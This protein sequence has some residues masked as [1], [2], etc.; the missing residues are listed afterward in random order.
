MKFLV[1]KA[2][3]PAEEFTLSAAYMLGAD[4][5]PLHTTQKIIINNGI[6]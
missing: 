1:F 3:K 6:I 2:G 5:I 4:N